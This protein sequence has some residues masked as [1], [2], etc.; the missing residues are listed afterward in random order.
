M[1]CIDA[2]YVDAGKEHLIDNAKVEWEY[3]LYGVTNVS[4]ATIGIFL[5]LLGIIVLFKNKDRPLFLNL[6]LSL[7]L[8]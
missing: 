3:W 6:M 5:N 2:G 1:A 7:F 8:Y 4:I